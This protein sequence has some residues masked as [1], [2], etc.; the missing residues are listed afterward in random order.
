MVNF[1]NGR[2]SCIAEAFLKAVFKAPIAGYQA[3]WPC[4]EEYTIVEWNKNN[5]QS[6]ANQIIDHSSLC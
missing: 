2:T 1:P 4:M 3:A 6:N 5:L